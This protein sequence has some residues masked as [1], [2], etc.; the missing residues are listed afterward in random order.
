M[1]KFEDM[2]LLVEI[3]RAGG[4]AAA[5]RRLNLS[6]AAMTSRLANMEKR[7]QT[8]LFNRT[9]RE[10]AL[11]RIGEDYYQAALRVIDEM[12]RA[13][14]ALMQS[15]GALNGSL[16]IGS[17]SDFARQYLSPAIT[18]FC[19][20]HPGVKVSLYIAEDVVNLISGRLDMSIRFGNLTDSNLVTRVINHN[21][22]VL[23]ASPAYLR[24]A[25]ALDVPDDL[26]NHR[27]LVMEREG[28]GMT[29][30]KFRSGS[31]KAS[32][33]VTPAMVCN[34][35]AILR[36]WSLSGA[37]IVCKSWWDV[38]DDIERGKLCVLFPDIFLGFSESDNESVGLQF[39]YPEGIQLP[40]IVRTFS[41][42]FIEWLEKV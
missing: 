38:K 14:S 7:Y 24:D 18:T 34:D 23:V 35:G 20:Q 19:A 13:E 25:P 37:G 28:L 6:P 22:R 17:P 41:D 21:H 12:G 30:W 31:G 32:V 27:C 26:K 2:A 15:D 10:I 29:E 11:T 4:L 1:G 5:G 8:R 16:R 42:F 36:Q 9:T 3:V 40:V 33:L 39:V